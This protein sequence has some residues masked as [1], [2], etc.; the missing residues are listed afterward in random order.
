MPHP[1]SWQITTL[2][3]TDQLSHMAF[4]IYQIAQSPVCCICW[5]PSATSVPTYQDSISHVRSYGNITYCECR[6]INTF[7]HA[8]HIELKSLLSSFQT[9]RANPLKQISYRMLQGKSKFC[10]VFRALEIKFFKFVLSAH[11]ICHNVASPFLLIGLENFMHIPLMTTRWDWAG[12]NVSLGHSK[13][14]THGTRRVYTKLC[15]S[16]LLAVLWPQALQI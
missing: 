3:R 2:M 4:R 1:H 5:R 9:S 8:R 14:N 16:W 10:L 11:S 15:C 6:N 7:G 12:L 13:E